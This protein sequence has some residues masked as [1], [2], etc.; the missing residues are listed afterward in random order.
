MGDAGLGDFM[1]R[2][3]TFTGAA[4]VGLV[5]AVAAA[6]QAGVAVGVAEPVLICVLATAGAILVVGVGG[7]LIKPM[8]ERW[9]RLL[10]A[11]ED[12]PGAVR[13]A[14]SPAAVTPAREAGAGEG[15][16]SPVPAG[17][18]PAVPAEPVAVPAV[19]AAPMPARA[20]RYRM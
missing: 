19:P 8:Q 14:A 13:A 7:G 12:E 6:I 16:G 20:G 2:A 10:T 4:V 1:P 11:W 9:E 3:F 15:A 5:G 17:S 18:A